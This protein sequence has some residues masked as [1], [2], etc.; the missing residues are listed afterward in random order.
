MSKSLSPLP[1][2]FIYRLELAKHVTPRLMKDEP[3]HRWFYFPHSFSPKLVELLFEEWQLPGGSVVID[4]FVGAG[5]TLCTARRYGYSAIGIDISPLSIFVSNAKVNNYDVYKIRRALQNVLEVVNKQEIIRLERSKRLRRA[6]TDAEFAVLICLRQAILTQPERIR[7]F[8]L[9]GLLKIQQ[10]ISRAVPDGG[11]FRWIDK[12]CLASA[13]LPTFVQCIETMITDLITVDHQ[14][15]GHW[16]ACLH[17]AR[18][19]ETLRNR[20]PELGNRCKALITSPP[21]PNRHDYS[22]IFQIELLTLGLSEKDI[23]KLRY[24]A[25]RSHVEARPPKK[26]LPKFVQ[27]ELLSYALSLL[28]NNIDSRI[29]PMLI[30]YFEDMNAVLCSA[31]KILANGGYLAFVVGNTRHA[32]VMIP[33]DEILLLLGKAIGYVALTSWVARLRGNSAQQMGRYGR[34]PARES[35]VILQKPT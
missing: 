17:D 27:P 23:F 26:I 16:S 14:T 34:E 12:E 5:T 29:K 25:L 33:V 8:L 35:V 18:R 13:I 1:N 22:R 24:E 3:I 11:W 31:Y 10:R 30:G 9:L 21:Y 28:P 4:P 32:G 20:Y 7:E 2:H 6:F 15:Q 19:L